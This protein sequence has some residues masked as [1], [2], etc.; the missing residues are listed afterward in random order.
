MADDNKESSNSMG[1]IL[2]SK[3]A[4]LGLAVLSIITI[5]S[6]GI[7]IYQINASSA[8]KSCITKSKQTQ[9]VFLGIAMFVGISTFL[10]GGIS[11]FTTRTEEKREESEAS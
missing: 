3:T 11:I 5:I 2:P 8:A 4:L 9:M 7:S 6:A 1:I 10:Y